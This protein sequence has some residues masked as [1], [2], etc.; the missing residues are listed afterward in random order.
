MPTRPGSVAATRRTAWAISAFMATMRSASAAS[1]RQGF[2]MGA[3]IEGQHQEFRCL[4]W[5]V[6]AQ[7]AGRGR[8][9][10][11]RSTAPARATTA[12]TSRRVGMAGEQ[13]ARGDEGAADIA[14]IAATLE[15]FAPPASRAGSRS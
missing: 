8:V 12:S 2:E 15:R 9:E 4:P 1:V 5:R 10:V 7:W 13:L 3:M 11:G 14:E 6:A